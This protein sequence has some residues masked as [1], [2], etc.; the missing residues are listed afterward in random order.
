VPTNTSAAVPRR[1]YRATHGRAV[2]GVARGLAEHLGI[3]VLL[4]RLAFVMLGFAAGAGVVAYG[5]FWI[6]VPQDTEAGTTTP[7]TSRPGSD[8]SQ[9]IAL[10]A[11][12]AGAMLL[13]GGLGVGIS[14]S[15]LLPLAL[16][17]FGV[18]L[19]WQQADEAQRDRWRVSRWRPSFLARGLVGVALVIA[20]GAVFLASQGEL[21]A[22]RDALIGTLVIV[23]GLALITGPW[24][25]R[26]AREL[27][28]ERRERI[29]SQE[30]A[31]VAAHVHDSVL[32]T[33]TLIQRH[34]EDPRE[35]VR[36]ARAQERELRAWLYRPAPEADA[37]L[38]GALERIAAE[39][40]DAHRATIEVVVVGEAPIDERLGALLMAAREAMVNAA[41]YAGEAAISV[42]GEVE[43]EQVTVFVRDRGKGFD[44]G[45]VPEDRLGIRQSIIGRMERNGGVAAVR[46][47][48]GDGTEVQLEMRRVAQ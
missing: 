17:A 38:S 46:S 30:R 21:G 29:R 37:V 4:V 9:L 48:P 45:A 27:A 5:A 40:E 16:T 35:V 44:L 8:R 6:L 33:L 15:L 13:A 32:H 20:G 19:V 42:Y 2:A 18:A 24:W 31:E 14:G 39:V 26:L 36:L 28:A 3:D 10:G 25:L 41:K 12:A 34:V 1:L 43:P 7:S 23:L 22:A 47:A 11:L